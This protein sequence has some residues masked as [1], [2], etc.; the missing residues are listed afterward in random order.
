MWLVLESPFQLNKPG[1]GN[2][3]AIRSALRMPSIEQASCQTRARTL[4]D[5]LVLK[6]EDLEGTLDEALNSRGDE[7]TKYK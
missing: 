6:R 4:V 5:S 3:V 1:L 7:V 2:A